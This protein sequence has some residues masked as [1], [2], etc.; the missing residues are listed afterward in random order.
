MSKT[1]DNEKKHKRVAFKLS[2]WYDA[3]IITAITNSVMLPG[4][5]EPTIRPFRPLV[6]YLDSTMVVVVIRHVV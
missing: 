6:L 3:I 2:L 1:E 5:T 4:P